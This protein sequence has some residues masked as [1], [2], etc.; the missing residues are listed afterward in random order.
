[1]IN[2]FNRALLFQDPSAEAAGKIC[3]SLKEAG[4]PYVVKTGGTGSAKPSVRIPRT[5]R[6]GNIGDGNYMATGGIPYSWMEGGT[7][8]TFQSIYVHKKDLT[9]AK[10]I[11]G[12]AWQ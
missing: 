6:T 4:I 8:N 12:I 1:M 7:A 9:K 3:S 10:E 5:G 2:I 11:C